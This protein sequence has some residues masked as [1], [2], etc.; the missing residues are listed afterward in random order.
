MART[1][2]YKVGVGVQGVPLH[3]Y[4]ILANNEQDAR[5]RA[6]NLFLDPEKGFDHIEVKRIRKTEVKR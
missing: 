1:Y 5:H 4:T 3:H 6:I 2:W